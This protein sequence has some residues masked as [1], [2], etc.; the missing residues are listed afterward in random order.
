[1]VT[2]TNGIEALALFRRDPAQF[3]LVIT[4]MTMPQMTGDQLAKELL[5]I[6]PD[7]P[8]VLCTGFS[9]EINERKAKHFGI[10][11]FLMKPFVLR[12]LATTVRKVID[13]KSR[14]RSEK[15]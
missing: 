5:K 14:L 8:V 6:R 11:A 2:R 3:D 15:G 7:I 13:E 12:E 4:D 10:S 9:H 1:M